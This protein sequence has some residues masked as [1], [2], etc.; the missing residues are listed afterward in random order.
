MQD[1]TPFPNFVPDMNHGI[2]GPLRTTLETLR[3][4]IPVR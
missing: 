1:G 2:S 3:P 4:D